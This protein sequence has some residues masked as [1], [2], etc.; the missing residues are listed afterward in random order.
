LANIDWASLS[1]GISANRF[2]IKL[3][4]A[5]ALLVAGYLIYASYLFPPTFGKVRIDSPQV[6]TR[7]RLVNDRFREQAWLE[8]RLQDVDRQQNV[9]AEVMQQARAAALAVGV[10]KDKPA[11]GEKP[12]ADVAIKAVKEL[13]TAATAAQVD[14]VE[15]D[16]RFHKLQS[17]RETLRRELIENELDDR[18]DLGSNSL[19][20]FK[21]GAAISPGPRTRAPLL[22]EMRMSPNGT[23][24]AMGAMA[25]PSFAIC[26][27]LFDFECAFLLD[28]LRGDS[29]FP[30]EQDPRPNLR[31]WGDL[32]RRWIDDVHFRRVIKLNAA[33]EYLHSKTLGDEMLDK[34]F[35]VSAKLERAFNNATISINKSLSPEKQ[36]SESTCSFPKTT[37]SDK[38]KEDNLD[39]VIHRFF[40]ECI[41]KYT[42]IISTIK[43]DTLFS[44]NVGNN[45]SFE[46]GSPILKFIYD[47][48]VKHAKLDQ[49][50][51]NI[52][53]K[54]I[55][56]VS[57]SC[58][59]DL[60][61]VNASLGP[62]SPNPAINN[63]TDPNPANSPAADSKNTYSIRE[64][65]VQTLLE[66]A[67]PAFQD[68]LSSLDAD[69]EI[70][71]DSS[72]D[73]PKEGQDP[74]A[75]DI[76]TTERKIGSTYDVPRIGDT[77][78]FHDAN[79]GSRS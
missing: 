62:A 73:L 20:L 38:D 10:G 60:L 7:E 33:D 1:A 22:I 23:P 47:D 16:D 34:V 45:I 42:S 11:E 64:N 57:T 76:S 31:D 9:L 15:F 26:K 25:G 72:Q 67:R 44:N 28:Y 36:L 51:K 46:S 30:G 70:E 37:S 77:R 17:Y 48:D 13:L 69:L 18:H 14:L 41:N 29:V 58:A 54:A 12:D 8:G 65:V 74:L 75:L 39:D 27:K 63:P 43:E 71:G 59:L 78:L 4:V 24:P 3:V 50:F 49:A 2:W 40:E 21:F 6:Y 53:G 61:V 5:C 66:C 19:Y 52:I 55:A 68:R 79:E 32:Y 35:T 56:S